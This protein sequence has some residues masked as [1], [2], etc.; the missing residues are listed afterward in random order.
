MDRIETGEHLNPT[1]EISLD[2][3]KKRTVR[4]IAALTGRTVILQAVAL[5]A[6]F[7]LTIFLSPTQF[8]VFF[9]VS[10]VIN[11]FAYFSDIGLA[12][13]L[14]QK[15]SQPSESDFRTTFTVQQSLVILLILVVVAT[16]PL[17]QKLYGLSG[18]SVY[19]LWALAFSLILSSL[20]TIPSV[21]LERSLRF[22]KLIIPQIV[23]TI[24]FYG[25]A[26]VLAWA[27]AGITSFTVAVLVRGI[28]GLAVMYY[29]SPWKPGFNFARGSLEKLLKFGLPYQANTLLAVLKDDGMTLVLGGI[30]GPAGVGLLS[31]AQKWAQAPLRF[32]MDQVIKVTFPSFARLQDNK[33]ELS[34]LASRSIFF[35][36]VLV[37][38]MLVGLA[39]LAEPLTEIIPRYEKWQ[40]ALL[41]LTLISVNS[42]LAAITTPLTNL[43]TAIGKIGLTFRLMIMWTLLTWLFVPLL[44]L[45]FHVNGAALGFSL[46]GIS[47]VV[48]IYIASHFVH[49]NFWENVGKPLAASIGMGI[50]VF[51]AGNLV[52]LNLPGM[53]LLII[54]GLAVYLAFIYLLVGA[55]ILTDLRKL[56]D[57]FHKK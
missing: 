45:R 20:K 34:K 56:Y 35:V 31:W 4:G 43:L 33:Q 53:V 18:S 11:F 32:F 12:A 5:I 30:I 50:V 7:L 55:S 40:P 57:E 17:W 13:A 47:S 27:G 26:V 49:I 9:L 54:F 15:K 22:D 25:V 16:T 6:T 1:E 38:P 24:L 21:K 2:V 42:M 44:A 3:V 29:L 19:L 41:A 51:L 23:E 37:F 14:I 36:S 28:S 39:I 52:P 48:A 8:G 10:A 46:V